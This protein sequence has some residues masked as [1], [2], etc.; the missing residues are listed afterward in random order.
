MHIDR[1]GDDMTSLDI[2]PLP[3]RRHGSIAANGDD[4][5]PLDRYRAVTHAIGRDDNAAANN[6][7]NGAGTGRAHGSAFA[8][9]CATENRSA[10][11]LRRLATMPET[12]ASAPS[13]SKAVIRP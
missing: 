13:A 10:L 5:A 12:S 8:I 9:A 7:I 2:D 4:L 1:A 6:K 3:S 11:R